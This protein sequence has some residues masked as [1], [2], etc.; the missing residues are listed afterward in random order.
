PTGIK[1]TWTVADNAN[2]T[3]Q[4]AQGTATGAMSQTLTNKTNVAQT[5]VYTVTPAGACTGADF[6]VTVTVNPKAKIANK[7][8]TICTGN[9]FP[10]ATNGTTGTGGEDLVPDGTTYSWTVDPNSNVTGQSAQNNKTTVA[11]TLNNGTATAQT[12]VYN[13]TPKS[14]DCIG[15]EFKV[16]VTVSPKAKVAN[17]TY[18][19]CSGETFPF[20]TVAADVVPAGTTY[21]WAKPVNDNVDGQS[22]Q[23]NKTTVAQ[24]LTNLSNTAQ[25]VVYTVTPKSGDCTGDDFTV[26]VKVN[27]KAKIADQTYTI[28]TGEAFPFATNGTTGTGGADLVPAGTTYSWTV[29]PNSN[30]TGQSAQNNKATV[31]QTLNNGTATAQTVVYNV[32]PKS[33]DCIGD[34]FKVTVTVNPKAKIANKTYTICSDESFTYAPVASD[35][36]PAGT[37]YSWDQPVNDNVEGQTGVQDATSISQTLINKSNVAQTVVYTVTPK[38]G[39]CIGADF[40]VTVTVNPQPVITVTPADDICNSSTVDLKTTFSSNVSGSTFTYY[41]DEACTNATTVTTAKWDAA[42]SNQLLDQTVTLYAKATA[43][44]CVSEKASSTVIIKHKPLAPQVED[45]NTCASVISDVRGWESLVKNYESGAELTW[46][47]GSAVVTPADFDMSVAMNKAY[48]VSQTQ[49]GCEGDKSTVRVHIRPLPEAPMVTNL[50][51]CEGVGTK[52]WRDLVTSRVDNGIKVWFSDI[53]GTAQIAEP[54]T[55]SYAN[56]GERTAYV[57][58]EMDG[59]L[60]EVVEVSSSVHPTPSFAEV[61]DESDE[62]TTLKVNGVAP[63]TYLLDKNIREEFDGEVNLGILSIGNH[64]LTVSDEIGC[65]ND[66]VLRIEPI[67]LVPDKFFTPNGDGVN[68]LW[69]IKGLERYPETKIFLHDRYGK[70]LAEFKGKDFNGWDGRYNGQDMPSTDYWYIIELRETGKRMVGHF[71]LRR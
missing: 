31:S 8:Y 25:T 52:A 24:T 39:D 30:V 21:S 23:D 29:D 9:E 35:V 59:C 1:Y 50:V 6:K 19:I 48:S 7:S 13:V 27:P 38:S 16:T 12:V 36:V 14:G 34:D 54:I 2:V 43:K 49:N 67:P 11:Q 45:I 10:F 58:I 37:T 63:F 17:K 32:T 53:D 68:D 56:P 28:C 5:V 47:D 3:G 33:G 42:A 65:K 69:T 46:Y 20:A 64:P 61:I 40:K 62:T 15:D 60:S 41:T 70:E 66:T 44:G 4:S 22:A 26:T 18:T 71:L 57:A 55:I 51:V